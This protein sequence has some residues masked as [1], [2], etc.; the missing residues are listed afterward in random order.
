MAGTH[1][2]KPIGAVTPN[3]GDSI[4]TGHG[5]DRYNLGGGDV[6]IEYR[7]GKICIYFYR[8]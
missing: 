8:K 5:I 2:K 7:F 4:K 3:W 1:L 6:D